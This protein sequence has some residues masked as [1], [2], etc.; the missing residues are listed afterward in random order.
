MEKTKID[1]LV[2]ALIEVQRKII[3]GILNQFVTKDEFYEITDEL[4]DVLYKH[5]EEHKQIKTKY[6]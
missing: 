3:E 2:D 1:E 6:L 4:R 5:I